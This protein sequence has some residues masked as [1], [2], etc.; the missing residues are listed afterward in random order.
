M[1]LVKFDRETTIFFCVYDL[2]RVPS[3]SSVILKIYIFISACRPR[4]AP[5]PP[6]LPPPSEYL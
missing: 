6:P 2:E 1:V 5:P 3:L 4:P